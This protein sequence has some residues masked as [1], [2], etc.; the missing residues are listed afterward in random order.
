MNWKI[1]EAQQKFS[2]VLNAAVAE[3]QLIYSQNKPIAAVVEVEIFQQFLAW[4]QRQHQPTLGDAFTQ[5]RQ[6][7]AEENYTIEIPDREDRINP[8]IDSLP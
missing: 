2:E 3:P 5:L 7:C 1:E 4:Q 8:F 6:L